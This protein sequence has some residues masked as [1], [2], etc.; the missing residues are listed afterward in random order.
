MKEIRCPFCG[1]ENTRG[2]YCMFCGNPLAG[3]TTTRTDGRTARKQEQDERWD[4]ET[5][6]I[7]SKGR[8]IAILAAL[9]VL[10]VSIAAVWFTQPRTSRTPGVSMHAF[11]APL[12]TPGASG[13]KEMT[14][15]LRETGMKPTGDPYQFSDTKYQHFASCMILDEQ[16]TFTTAASQEGAGITVCHYFE[17]EAGWHSIHNPGPVLER[18]LE[19]LKEKFG[20]PVIRGAENYYYWERDGSI[21]ALDYGYNGTIRLRFYEKTPDASV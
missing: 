5:V 1:R 15:M 3:G 4:P 11:S 13:L 7:K 14:A 21:L 8:R 2:K 16:T 9:L 18:L 19:K 10:A 17:E 20:K 6:Y 12:G